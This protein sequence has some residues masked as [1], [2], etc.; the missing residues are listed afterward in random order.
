[1]TE[2]FFFSAIEKCRVKP[3][4]EGITQIRAYAIANFRAGPWGLYL[5]SRQDRPNEGEELFEMKL[6]AQKIKC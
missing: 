1:M 5:V 4:A 2:S 3:K 6:P